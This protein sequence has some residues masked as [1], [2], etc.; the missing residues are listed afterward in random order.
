MLQQIGELRNDVFHFKRHL[1]EE[2]I[3][4]LG[5]KRNLLEQKAVIFEGGLEQVVVVPEQP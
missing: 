3:R 1:G 5:N 4:F 2:D